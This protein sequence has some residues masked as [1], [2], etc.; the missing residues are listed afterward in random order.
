MAFYEHLSVSERRVTTRKLERGYIQR[1]VVIGPGAMTLRM[2]N[3]R[4]GLNMQKFFAE[5]VVR[6]MPHPWISSRP[7]WIKLGAV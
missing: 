4:F 3:E 6:W 1:S 2:R 7:G 5:G